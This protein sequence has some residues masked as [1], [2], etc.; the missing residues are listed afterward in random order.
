MKYEIPE[1]EYL[2]SGHL[3]CPGCG[4]ALAMRYTLK[5]LGRKTIIVLPAC[6]WS[7][8]AGPYPYFSL[9]VPLYHTAFETAA[10]VAA[11]VKAALEVRG[12]DEAQVLAW[13]G[14]G[15]TFDIGIS[16]LSGV[17]ERNE[18]IIYACYD[19]E[20]YMNTGIQRSSATPWGA[21]TTTTP[22]E[23]SKQ[24]PKKNIMEVIVAHRIPYAATASIAFPTD[25]IWKL[26]KAKKIRGTK[27]IHMFSP[28]PTGW[29]AP[30]EFSV[31]LARLAVETKVFPL[32]EVED[33]YKYTVNRQSKGIPVK[34]YLELQ[35]RFKHLREEDIELIQQ[36]VDREWEWLMKKVEWS[37][38]DG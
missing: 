11:G 27:F 33:G 19:N 16:A 28:C 12:E 1:E 13:A 24:R 2:S 5:A 22:A 7:I 23:R 8:I 35:G 32:Y 20:A 29:R 4:A 15:T 14:D 17:A 38:H 9:N 26:T 21:W 31:K 18:D 36:N 34:E 10:S 3:A 30:S 6:C 25:L 37:W